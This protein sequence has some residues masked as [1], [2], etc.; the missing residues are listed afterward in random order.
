MEFIKLELSFK[1]QCGFWISKR[2]RDSKCIKGHRSKV[3]G[4]KE[5]GPTGNQAVDQFAVSWGPSEGSRAQTR[6]S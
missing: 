2:N 5:Q 3:R 4:G 1:D 6:E